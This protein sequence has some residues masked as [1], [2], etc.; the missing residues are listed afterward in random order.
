MYPVVQS[1]VSDPEDTGYFGLIVWVVAQDVLDVPALEVL[2]CQ[3]LVPAPS[4]QRQFCINSNTL[5]L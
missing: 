3:C 5:R 4:D 1:F 2:D